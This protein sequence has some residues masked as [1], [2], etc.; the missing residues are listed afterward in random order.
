LHC[1][2]ELSI[3]PDQ[4]PRCITMLMCCPSAGTH[5]VCPVTGTCTH[6]RQITHVS[7][8]QAARAC[9][10]QHLKQ[11]SRRHAWNSCWQSWQ[12][13]AL[14]CSFIRLYNT[15]AAAQCT[16]SCNRLCSRC[17]ATSS[18]H[19]YCTDSNYSKQQ[20]LNWGHADHGRTTKPQLHTHLCDIVFFKS[21][22]ISAYVVS[23]PSG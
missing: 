19:Q 17:A 18:A 9:C 5:V 8:Q 11:L 22:S 3:D 1:S 23:N 21:L 6:T 13:V 20:R 14:P 7:A 2:W 12:P 15:A 16:I 10:C 4:G